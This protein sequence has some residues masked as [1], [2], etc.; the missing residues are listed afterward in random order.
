MSF[1]GIIHGIEEILPVAGKIVGG[2]IGLRSPI[3]G[4]LITGVSGELQAA[5]VNAEATVTTAKSGQMKSDL[6]IADFQSGLALTQE[7][8]S[9]EGKVLVYDGAALQ[10][11]I[12]AQ[13]AAY[14]AVAKLKASF[15]IQP[16]P[17]G[18]GA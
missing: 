13:V 9:Y 16:K 11:A 12:N 14:N 17:T 6:V 8:L 4:G 10:D 2:L 5:I 1:M 7:I 15:S 18:Q 3:L